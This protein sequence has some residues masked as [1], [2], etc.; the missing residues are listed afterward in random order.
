MQKLMLKIMILLNFTFCCYQQTFAQCHIDD[1]TALKALYESTDGDNWRNNEG[2]EIVKSD[3]YPSNC[4]LEISY[5]VDLNKEGRVIALVLINNL[6]NGS[7]PAELSKLSSLKGLA[8]SRNQLDGSIPSEIGNLNNL[9]ILDIGFNQFSGCYPSNIRILCD[10]LTY[11]IISEGNNFITNWENFCTVGCGT[12][13]SVESFCHIDDWT[14]LK[15]LYESTDGDN[16][17]NNK[18]WEIVK[19]EVPPLDCDLRRLHGVV[20]TTP[21]GR[22]YLLLLTNNQL[23]GSLPTELG[24]LSKLH[25]LWLTNNKLSGSIPVELSYLNNLKQLLLSGNQLDGNIPSQFYYSPPNFPYFK[26]ELYNN[27]LSCQNI[28]SIPPP[29]PSESTL[30]PIGTTIIHS[31]QY[32]RPLN[33]KDIKTNIFDTLSVNRNLNLQ[34][35]FPFDTDFDYVYQ[36]FRNG[37]IIPDAT[38]PVFKIDTILPQNVGKYTLQIKNENCLTNGNIFTSISDPIYVILKGY[39]L[40]GESVE[41]TKL[42]VEFED[43]ANKDRYEK[44]IFLDNGGIWVDKCDCNRELH[45]YDFPDDSS[46]I[47]QAYVALDQKIKS[48]KMP[49][50]IDGGFNYKLNNIGL[51]FSAIQTPVNYIQLDNNPKQAYSIHYNYPDIDY[52]DSV[53]VYQLDSGLDITNLVKNDLFNPA[54][55]ESCYDIS[56]PAYNFVNIFPLMTEEIVPIDT[57]YQDFIGHGTFGYRSIS[58]GLEK[59][60]NSKIV[61]LKIIEEVKNGNLFDLICALYHA[62]DQNADVIN[63]SAGYRGESSGILETAL[64][65]AREKGIFVVAAA[66]NDNLNIDDEDEVP[67]YPAYYASQYYYF[68]KNNPFGEPQLDS[69]RYNNIISVSAVNRLDELNEYSSYGA[70]SVTIAAPGEDIYGYGLKGTDAVGSGTSIA[71]FLTTQV[72]A[73]EIARDNK[74][75]IDQIWV[76][77]ENNYLETNQNLIGKTRTGKQINFEW[78]EKEIGGCIDCAACNYFPYATFDDGT[79]YYC[80]EG[81][82][83]VIPLACPSGEYCP[84]CRLDDSCSAS[85]ASD[86]MNITIGQDVILTNIVT[87]NTSGYWTGENVIHFMNV[88]GENIP[89]F[90][91]N[92]TGIFKLYYTI[93]SEH[94]QE[95][96]ILLVNVSNPSTIKNSDTIISQ[97]EYRLGA[98][99]SL[100][101]YPNPVNDQLYI[102]WVV[103]NRNT[104][105]LINLSGKV[106]LEDQFDG[107][108]FSFD[109][110]GFAKGMYLLELQNESEKCIQKLLIE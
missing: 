80:V 42:M 91:A 86:I 99:Q 9:E 61:P 16:W 93:K 94:C 60:I 84:H 29:N 19:E 45:L 108:Q 72:L 36:W 17:K 26:M 106:L 41:Y 69:V 15:A 85:L 57:N 18:G 38:E 27:Y 71:A 20:Q 22:V 105:R 76:D 110:S 82:D 46:S 6:L 66:G 73:H 96:Y 107:N 68:Y 1:W 23:N 90:Y 4:N 48:T 52:I 14:A 78:Q 70:Q 2:W 97:S 11:N 28:G 83:K 87:S 58:G 79:C 21:C 56:A 50:D 95:S 103:G 7:I 8:L 63:I 55:A 43:Q 24:D 39:D 75:S 13:G 77:F 62:I 88:A 109:A 65:M 30:F 100:H 102:K 32:Y 34:V 40:L 35:D 49:G 31:P 98:E 54:P 59:A 81:T 10:Q 64:N 3:S 37:D 25:Y 74:R 44:E 67:Q 51:D 89:Y 12:C 33:Y 47:A 101:L 5:G 92:A 53:N 104:L